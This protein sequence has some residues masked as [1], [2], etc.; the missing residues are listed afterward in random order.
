MSNAHDTGTEILDLITSK[1][2]ASESE[3]T[4]IASNKLYLASKTRT[5]SICCMW[6]VRNPLSGV[7]KLSAAPAS[8]GGGVVSS[9][10]SSK[11]VQPISWS[12]AERFKKMSQFTNRHP[13]GGFNGVRQLQ[14]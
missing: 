11:G 3:R 6:R 2:M 9:P 14:R 7:R 5:L 13:P 12:P 1:S 4:F 8:A 10:M